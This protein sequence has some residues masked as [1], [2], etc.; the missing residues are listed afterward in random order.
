MQI[1][2]DTD[3]LYKVYAGRVGSLYRII[4]YDALTLCRMAR[5]NGVADRVVFLKI[6]TFPQVKPLISLIERTICVATSFEV[7][8]PR[9]PLVFQ[10]LIRCVEVIWICIPFACFI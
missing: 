10:I 7:R 1:I 3:R 8:G 9:R 5:G 6:S 2:C 4:L